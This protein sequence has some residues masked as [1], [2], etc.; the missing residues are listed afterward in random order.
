MPR[1]IPTADF[2]CVNM[3]LGMYVARTLHFVHAVQ[4]EQQLRRS[5]GAFKK[6]RGMYL[7]T[8]AS[9]EVG[10]R[11]YSAV[12]YTIVYSRTMNYRT[13]SE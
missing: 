13:E 7:D 1:K 12:L 8:N 11:F 5:S 2:E 10:S 3:M 6:L 9:D 4:F